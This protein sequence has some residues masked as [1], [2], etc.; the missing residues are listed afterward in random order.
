MSLLVRAI[1][2]MRIETASTTVAQNHY[3]EFVEMDG[4]LT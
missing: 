3:F 2:L 4:D 1:R